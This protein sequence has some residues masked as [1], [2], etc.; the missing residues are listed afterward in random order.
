VVAIKHGLL[1]SIRAEKISLKFLNI[2]HERLVVINDIAKATIE[3]VRGVHPVYVFTY[4]G[5][6]YY[7]MH[8]SSWRQGRKRAGL[9]HIRVHDLKH[10]FGARLTNAGVSLEHKKQLLGH[11][12]NVDITTHY[13]LA[14][15]QTLIE[16]ANRVCTRMD[17]ISVASFL[18][19]LNVNA[20]KSS[21][22]IIPFTEAKA[23]KNWV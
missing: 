15:I 6:P 22:S 9:P 12:G 10:T 2:K 3:E 18:K 19:Q 4:N 23:A 16:Q 1:G 5:K 13:S 17:D 14:G 21:G 20:K 11:R 8:S 7:N